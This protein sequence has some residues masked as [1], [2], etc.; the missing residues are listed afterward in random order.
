ME[1]V[2][3]MSDETM[4]LI[5]YQKLFNICK[6]EICIWCPYLSSDIEHSTLDV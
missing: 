2:D 6:L 4:I 3:P 1:F 5:V